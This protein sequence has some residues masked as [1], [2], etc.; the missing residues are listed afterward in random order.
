MHVFTVRSKWTVL[1]TV[2]LTSN[3]L[4][5]TSEWSLFSLMAGVFGGPYTSMPGQTQNA[6]QINGQSIIGGNSGSAAGNASFSHLAGMS[7]NQLYDVMSQMKVLIEQNQQ[8][9]RQILVANPMLTKS[10]FQAQI[11]LGMVRPPQ[12]MPNIQQSLT[13]SPQQQ[14]QTGQQGHV[15][16]RQQGQT[17]P[18]QIQ[19]QP[20]QQSQMHVGQH[21]QVPVTTQSQ[22][23]SAMQQP[24]QRPQHIPPHPLMQAGQQSQPHMPRQPTSQPVQQ[25]SQGRN[26]PMHLPIHSAPQNLPMQPQLPT[27]LSGQPQHT[28][29]QSSA[30]IHQPMQPPLPQQPRP[31]LQPPMHQLQNQQAQNI[32]FQPSVVP[33]QPQSQ[34]KFQHS[35]SN[36]Q[37]GMGAPFQ[38]HAQPPL[39][40]HP[41]PQQ[42]YQMNS[43]SV[44][45]PVSHSGSDISG[46]SMGH[47]NLPAV[48]HGIQT[49]RGPNMG[50]G[51]SGMGPAASWPPVP[52]EGVTN[53]V[54]GSQPSTIQTGMGGPTGLG[55]GM[56][57]G[58]SESGGPSTGNIGSGMN[59]GP[60]DVAGSNL[61]RSHGIS[62]MQTQAVPQQQ[63]Q[64]SHMQL[65]PDQ[66]KALLQQVMSLTPEQINSLPVEQRQ[67]IL[68][69]QQMFR[70]STSN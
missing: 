14:M 67:Q 5:K 57:G 21:G 50:Q 12:V 31:P 9:A 46:H 65:S 33:Q 15:Q 69:L 2:A 39:P 63:Q 49:G 27:V 68:Q 20:R 53:S 44:V 55:G 58:T 10:L 38:P 4:E 34:T 64:I 47:G 61:V 6:G 52:P 43:G 60:P 19:P 11:M 37:S 62:E 28:L 66:E 41:P 32:G 7:K 25:P 24:S 30:G 56:I 16:P 29:S 35:G 48:G 17:N 59:T 23:Q 18:V 1:E 36:A 8:Q 42:L 54:S 3:P 70:G 13:Q 51:L 45:G 22:P 40:S 26:L